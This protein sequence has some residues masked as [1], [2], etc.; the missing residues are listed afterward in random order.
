LSGDVLTPPEDSA[1]GAFTAFAK[2]A[3]PRLRHALAAAFGV[4]RGREALTDALA[5][6]WE[7]WD[8]VE[9]ADNPAGYV[10]RIACR[11]AMRGERRSPAPQVVAAD[12]LP[13][14]EPAL[15]GAL[16]R[17]SP[18]Q[19]QVVVLVEGFAWTHRET[20]ELLGVAPSTVQKHLERGLAKLRSALGVSI[21]V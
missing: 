5:Y 12:R 15:S 20:A 19:R 6:A 7:H 17:L 1:A 13:W 10:Y 8:R 11:Y 14:I 3:E 16:A 2:Q 18:M 9:G 4:Q 21:D